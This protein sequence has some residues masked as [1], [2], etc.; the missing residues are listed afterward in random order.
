[1][2]PNRAK[3]GADALWRFRTLRSDTFLFKH[4]YIFVFKKA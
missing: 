2:V 1:M 4:K 3:I